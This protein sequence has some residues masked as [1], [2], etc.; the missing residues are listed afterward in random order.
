M[1]TKHDIINNAIKKGN[2]VGILNLCLQNKQFTEICKSDTKIQ[3]KILDFFSNLT[4]DDQ[5]LR[6]IAFNLIFKH[7]L[8][9]E[10]KI[11]NIISFVK[12]LIDVRSVDTDTI[13]QLIKLLRYIETRK[14]GGWIYVNYKPEQEK[15]Y[16]LSGP[17]KAVKIVTNDDQLVKFLFNNYFKISSTLKNE[18]VYQ[19]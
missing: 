14:Q 2:V 15:L 3:K 8:T 17:E 19:F 12:K 1:A 13:I 11:R 5:Q 18:Q 16:T 7:E 9:N 4:N 6:D 10:D